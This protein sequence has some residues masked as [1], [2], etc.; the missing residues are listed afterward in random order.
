MIIQNTMLFMDVK[1]V[2]RI[3][4]SL[5]NRYNVSVQIDK[6]NFLVGFLKK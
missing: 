2:G 4:V 5:I 3:C 6:F 1:L